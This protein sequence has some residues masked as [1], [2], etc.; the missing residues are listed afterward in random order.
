MTTK[1]Q[2]FCTRHLIDIGAMPNPVQGLT[3]VVPDSSRP[4]G[5]RD[6]V[7]ADYAPEGERMWEWDP[8]KV[9]LFLTKKQHEGQAVRG[10]DLDKEAAV[11]NPFGPN[12]GDFLMAHPE[13]IRKIPCHSEG[14]VRSITFLAQK[15]RF[16]S[17]LLCVRCLVWSGGRWDWDYCW[18][19]NRW[20]GDC[21][22]VVLRE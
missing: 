3:L 9:E 12:L 22:A 7:P 13:E 21:P 17:G 11:L 20:Y 6:A 2:L 1:R 16:S 18:L 14:G 19:G 10:F 8:T 15:Y 5:Y 4:G